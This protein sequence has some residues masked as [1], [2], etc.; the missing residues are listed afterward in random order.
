MAE[1]YP[2]P[3]PT[4]EVVPAAFT[5]EPLSIR[6]V[7]VTPIPRGSDGGSVV[8]WST[9]YTVAAQTGAEISRKGLA[10]AMT[11]TARMSAKHMDTMDELHDAMRRFV[12]SGKVVSIEEGRLVRLAKQAMD[13]AVLLD[14]A[15]ALLGCGLK[16]NGVFGQ[17]F[18]QLFRE[19]EAYRAG[20]L[21]RQ[22]EAA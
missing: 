4:V 6:C 22:E 3:N 15:F 11:N 8:E 13:E 20:M 14:Y 10:P 2:F 1:T 12:G 7:S 17:R 16:E 9:Q 19:A 21:E 5:T 18:Q